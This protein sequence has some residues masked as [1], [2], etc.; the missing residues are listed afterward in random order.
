MGRLSGKNTFV[1]GAAGGIGLETSILFAQEGANVLLADISEAALEKAVE[2]V[3]EFLPA[4]SQQKI[5]GAK[6][7][8]SKE[9]DVQKAIESLDEFGGVD[10]VFNNAGIM[11]ADVSFF[12]SQRRKRNRG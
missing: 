12:M 4:G 7:D 8:V 10:V 9:A 1:T 5:V 6:V 3:K 11:H 2:K